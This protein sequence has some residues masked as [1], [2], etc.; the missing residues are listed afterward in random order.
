MEI[1]PGLVFVLVGFAI[2]GWVVSPGTARGLDGFAA[3]FLPYRD[4]GWPRGVQ[5]GDPVPWS[6]SPP[7]RPDRPA[8]IVEISPADAPVTAAL[9]AGTVVRGRAVRQG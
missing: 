8:E 9:R 1:L 6:W 7:S 2:V 5:E 3:G 4:A